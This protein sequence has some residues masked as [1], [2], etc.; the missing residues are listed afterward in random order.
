MSWQSADVLAVH[1]PDA[2]WERAVR[3]L[4]TARDATLVCH[5]APDGDALGSMLALA[6]GLRSLGVPVTCTWGD[7]RWTVP[8]S[9][10]W[11][12]DIE[13]VVPPTEVDGAP[14]VLVVLDTGS[15]DRLG[16]LAPLADTCGD[17]VVVDHHAH[18]SAEETAL[19]GIRLVDAGAAATA[20]VVEA[21]LAR[22]GVPLDEQMALL[23]YTGLVTDTGSFQHAVTTPAVHALAARLLAAGAQPQRVAQQ[24]WGSRP[25]GFQQ[26]LAA[27][28]GRVQ[29]EPDAA[30][31]RGL[32]W[33][34][35]T[36]DDLAGAAIGLDEVES[37]IDVVRTAREADV[38]AVLK[39]DVDGSYRVSTRSRGRT[40]VGA[41]CTELGGGG[42]S[43]AAGFTSR[44]D[45]ARTAQRLR[46][47]LASAPTP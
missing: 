11:L 20:A 16:V 34:F 15:R 22:L 3:V 2:E 47:A 25:F 31:G 44:D 4:S 9:Y 5:V 32:V 10:T 23:L 27:A 26:V 35:T 18:A 29:L 39:Q 14:S 1:L 43:L 19:G 28:L 40:D 7:D 33:T 41:V 13:T 42:H 46:T 36:S 30:D 17:L 21:L 8:P 37:V 45:V 24:L 12:P 6:R 38:A